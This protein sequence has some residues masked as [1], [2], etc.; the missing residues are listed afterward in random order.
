MI[1]TDHDA[2]RTWA[3]GLTV[4]RLLMS[5]LALLGGATAMSGGAVLVAD[6]VNA[7]YQARRAAIVPGRIGTPVTNAGM[8]YLVET[9]AVKNSLL[10][11]GGQQLRPG[12]GDVLVLIGVVMTNAGREPR[13]FLENSAKIVTTA[14]TEYGTLTGTVDSLDLAQIR[15]DRQYSGSLAFQVPSGAL[16]DASIVIGDLWGNGRIRIPLG[17]RS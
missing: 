10:T 11:D 14:G 12:P 1:S 2:T 8:T 5:V 6:Q 3:R 16:S 15:P 17:R 9:V 7:E 4:G 13:T